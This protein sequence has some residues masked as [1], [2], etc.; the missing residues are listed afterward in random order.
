M[1]YAEFVKMFNEEYFDGK[2]SNWDKGYT[3]EALSGVLNKLHNY[4]R[5]KF[6]GVRRVICL[7]CARG[8]EVD[9]WRKWGCE[10][11]GVEISLYALKTTNIKDLVHGDV[12]FLPFKSNSFDLAIGTELYEHIPVEFLDLAIRET[13]RVAPRCFATI[14]MGDERGKEDRD[15]TH[16][17]IK[18]KS[19]WV[20]VFSQYYAKVEFEEF[21]IWKC[22]LCYR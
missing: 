2:I 7:G 5:G 17:T 14:P 10:A 3:W 18:P 19:W 6:K 15:P 11:Y 12:R 4:I 20:N 8:F 16:V 22:L 13:C 21:E 1:D 9:I